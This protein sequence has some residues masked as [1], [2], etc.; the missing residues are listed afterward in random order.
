MFISQAPSPNQSPPPLLSLS[1]SS[2]SLLFSLT[3]IQSPQAL[4]VSSAPSQEGAVVVE[5]GGVVVAPVT[6]LLRLGYALGEV[7]SSQQDN[8]GPVTASLTLSV[9]VVGVGV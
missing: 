3:I 4:S 7:L 8:V 2:L 9:V 5:V 6:K 1:L